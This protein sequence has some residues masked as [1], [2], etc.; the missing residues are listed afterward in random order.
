MA[1]SRVAGRPGSPP[2]VLA[3]AVAWPVEAVRRGLWGV[4]SAR[5]MA[6]P[7][8]LERS[9]PELDT[10]TGRRGRERR[11]ATDP[12]ARSPKVGDSLA[13]GPPG[14]LKC[15]WTACVPMALY[16]WVA[17]TAEQRRPWRRA[18]FSPARAAGHC[19][20]CRR[21]GHALP[22][23]ALSGPHVGVRAGL[24]P[25]IMRAAGEPVVRRRRRAARD[26]GRRGGCRR[27][28]ST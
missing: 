2:A 18:G 3:S 4:D 24:D 12:T 28:R 5:E 13:Y 6:N 22:C 7:A 21:G 23:C 17:P 19:G 20:C 25:P 15:E 26:S 11:R 10:G 9:P 14:Q 27:C 1:H 16:S 8:S